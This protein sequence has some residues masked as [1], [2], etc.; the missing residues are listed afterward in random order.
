MPKVS[1]VVPNYNHARYLARRIDSIL[2]QSYTDFELL[3]LDDASP[4]NSREVIQKYADD[5][6]VRVSFNKT[7]TGNTYLQ[8]RKGLES[9]SGEYVWLAESDD[10]AAPELLQRLVSSLD[11]DSAVGIAV[12]NSICVDE[13]DVPSGEFLAEWQA[14][15]ESDYDLSVFDTDFVMDG[16]DYCRKYMVPWNTIP[17]ASAA[18]FRRE[19]FDSIGGPE[20]GMRLCGDWFSYCRIL[21][22]FRI[23][24]VHD[25]L[26][27]FRNHSANV[28]SRTKGVDFVRQGLF[29]QRYVADQLGLSADSLIRR[30]RP[31]YSQIV[32]AQERQPPRNKVPFS[33]IPSVVREAVRLGHGIPTGVCRILLK[34]TA[35]R[36]ARDSGLY[37]R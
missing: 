2:A 4:D 18:V 27:F 28:R 34:E 31:H 6:R 8:W 23:A 10:Y 35:A 16:R 17:N 26:N 13:H 1:I 3:I 11:A 29:V 15:G 14:R 9:T 20:T 5:K 37:R 22:H 7:N 21:M 36:I 30:V 25:Q 33:R 24:R 32:V 19:A 12:C